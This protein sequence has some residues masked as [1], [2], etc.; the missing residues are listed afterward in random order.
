MRR[1][2]LLPNG[3]EA[4]NLTSCLLN[5]NWCFSLCNKEFNMKKIQYCCKSSAA[6]GKGYNTGI[7]HNHSSNEE[8]LTITQATQFIHSDWRKNFVMF[9][10]TSLLLSDC[11]T[12][13]MIFI[14]FNVWIFLSCLRLLQSI[15]I[16]TINKCKIMTLLSRSISLMPGLFSCRT[17]GGLCRWERQSAIKLCARTQ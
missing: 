12:S 7:K 16:R 17:Q 15:Q 11:H 3:F 10:L 1:L 5:S 14:T 13:N 8:S 2:Q 6:A 4:T 9:W